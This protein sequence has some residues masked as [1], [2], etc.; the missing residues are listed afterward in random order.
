[1][2]AELLTT[3][4]AH[5]C[6]VFEAKY[7]ERHIAKFY[8]EKKEKIKSQNLGV[9]PKRVIPALGRLRQEDCEV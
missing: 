3:S 7:S 9:Q 5:G 8:S 2:A 6:S 4:P 1:M